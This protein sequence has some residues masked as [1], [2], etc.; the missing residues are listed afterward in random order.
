VKITCLSCDWC[1]RVSRTRRSEQHFECFYRKWFGRWLDASSV[2]C[3]FLTVAGVIMSTVDREE[4][5][6]ASNPRKGIVPQIEVH[7]L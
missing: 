7:L 1:R 2:P 5:L 3:E 6:R 4:F